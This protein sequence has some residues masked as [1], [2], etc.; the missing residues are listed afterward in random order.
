MKKI[1]TLLFFILIYQTNFSQSRTNKVLPKFEES[2]PEIKK[3]IGW[4]LN[5]TSG[6]WIE[7]ENCIYQSE[8]SKYAISMTPQNFNWIK[9][10]KIVY[11]G[12]TYYIFLYETNSGRYKYP[13]IK[14]DW[15]A[16]KQM[17]FLILTE[18]EYSTIKENIN[19]QSGLEIKI[20]SKLH[21]YFSDRYNV[22][23]GENTYNEENLIARIIKVID[24][25]DY[26][27]YCLLLNSQNVDNVDVIRF[28][29]PN[30]S[31]TLK[32]NYLENEYFEIT[33]NEFLKMFI[34]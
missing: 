16:E 1:L 15:E 5:N 27:E 4:A 19:K 13:S 28:K 8:I 20:S 11:N 22:L 26:F 24:N 32:K 7:N 31:C 10:N 34:Y 33:R 21:G 25:P 14:K 9:I 6:K 23:G 12:I 2:S 29:L 3:A 30:N 17:Q 18:S